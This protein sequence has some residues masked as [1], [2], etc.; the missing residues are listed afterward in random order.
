MIGKN[1][2]FLAVFAGLAVAAVFVSCVPKG[3]PASKTPADASAAAA[4][5]FRG[6]VSFVE[7]TVTIDGTAAET[8]AKVRASARVEAGPGSSCEIIFD[9]RNIVRIMQNTTVVLDFGQ[10]V[11][12][13]KLERGGVAAVLK[14]LDKVAGKDSFVVRGPTASAGVRGTCLCVWA[15][16]D[17][18]YVCACNG[19]VH[20]LDSS[21]SNELT[22][23]AP[24]HN[25]RIYRA[26]G[27]AV[28][29]ETAGILYHS[30]AS[31]ESL[32]AKIGYQVDW[33]K[34]D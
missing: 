32:A 20:T 28:S 24:H 10:A 34:A 1:R 26:K 23:T 31:V 27:S 12:E 30:D 7:G 13:I 2:F 6:S 4:P 19:T 21:G 14:K 22:I 25:A 9:D 16:P 3:S 11:K 29:V 15:E 18:T 17:S 8:G 5:D 33:L